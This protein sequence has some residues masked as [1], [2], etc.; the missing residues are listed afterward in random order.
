MTQ[1]SV[2]LSV[3][4]GTHGV[5]AGVLN[6]ET[7]ELL[8]CADQSIGLYRLD[9]ERVEQDAE[10]ILDAVRSVMQQALRLSPLRPQAMALACQ[11]STVVAWERDSLRP[12]G[13]ALSWQDSRGL[14]RLG[15]LSLSPA[16]VKQLSGLVLSAHYGAS[17]LAWLIEHY[18]L[19]PSEHCMGPLVS[20]LIQGL[21]DEKSF[22]C[23]ESNAG[24]TQLMNWKTAQWDPDLLA[25]FGVSSKFLPRVCPLKSIYGTVTIPGSVSFMAELRGVKQEGESAQL[26][27]YV[28]MHLPLILACGDQNAAAMSVL[29]STDKTSILVNIGSGAFTL[30]LLD[31]SE[32]PPESLLI[33]AGYSDD[34]RRICLLEGTVNSAGLA[35]TEFCK[36]ELGAGI[37]EEA[38]FASLPNWLDSNADSQWVYMNTLGGL[39]SPFW[40]RGPAAEFVRCDGRSIPAPSQSESAVA[41]V[42][43]IVFLVFINCQVMQSELPVQQLIVTGGLSRL[44]GLCQRLADLSQLPVVQVENKEATLVGAAALSRGLRSLSAVEVK[45]RFSPRDNVPLRRRFDVFLQGI[46]GLN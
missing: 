22:V 28:D 32:T 1:A 6:G 45:R 21:T 38:L 14:E 33:T 15:P 37:Q 4:I 43:S 2:I 16:K 29:G 7:G 11:R 30:R 10:E 34:Q 26:T 17:K 20:F 13:P 19:K 42:E 25:C 44:E 39:G 36:S 3:D 23:D 27:T 8:G 31:A 9:Q 35:I 46:E 12:C 18:R 40:R 41:V 5:R 24:R